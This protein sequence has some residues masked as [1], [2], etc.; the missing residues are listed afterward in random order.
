MPSYCFSVS[1]DTI[2]DYIF[3]EKK[4]RENYAGAYIPNPAS[5][6]K[7]LTLSAGN[8]Y[9]INY[10]RYACK[11]YQKLPEYITSHMKEE[12]YNRYYDEVQTI[13]LTATNKKNELH[14]LLLKYPYYGYSEWFLLKNQD[15]FDF[16]FANCILNAPWYISF[17]V[18]FIA[19]FAEMILFMFCA[20]FCLPVVK[21]IGYVLDYPKGC[22]MEIQWFSE[23]YQE[24]PHLDQFAIDNALKD[25]L[26]ELVTQI[27]NDHKT[28]FGTVVTGHFDDEVASFDS[29]GEDGHHHYHYSRHFDMFR[30]DLTSTTDPDRNIL[31]TSTVEVFSQSGSQV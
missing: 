24:H 22:E 21:L 8:Y 27:Q 15:A 30:L 3:A 25:E 12:D 20:V 26:D 16:V 9:G 2:N 31:T 5:L 19:F 11:E 10:Y 17:T 7:I 23:F 14:N 18:G 29:N 28:I 13:C 6:N 4:S 1:K